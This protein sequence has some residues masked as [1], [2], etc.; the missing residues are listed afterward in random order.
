MDGW[1]NGREWWWHHQRF[2][3]DSIPGCQW[4]PGTFHSI[5]GPAE[6]EAPVCLSVRG[7]AEQ[8]HHNM[9]VMLLPTSF[10]FYN[11]STRVRVV[12]KVAVKF[13]NPAIVFPV[14]I[15]HQHV[16]RLRFLYGLFRNAWRW[17][18]GVA[19]CA[20]VQMSLLFCL[21]LRHES[22]SLRPRKTPAQKALRDTFSLTLSLLDNA[23]MFYKIEMRITW[24]TREGRGALLC[25]SSER[26]LTG[27]HIFTR[28]GNDPWQNERLVNQTWQQPVDKM[29]A[30]WLHSTQ[31]GECT[32]LRVCH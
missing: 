12:T 10:V 9:A 29:K 23:Q 11:T 26:L 19:V 16:A 27:V 2:P 31:R 14:R 28:R 4:E 30:Y 1:R 22:V 32:I 6:F 13:K 24:L 17:M 8:A 5:T 20:K 7:W 18:G 15:C 3:S 25:L 21:V